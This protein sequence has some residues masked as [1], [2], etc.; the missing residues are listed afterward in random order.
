MVLRSGGLRVII[1]RDD[2]EPAHVHVRGDG[3]CKINLVG[4]TGLPELVW[5]RGMTE[6]EKRRA[7]ATVRE[8][9]F[10]LLEQWR[11]IHG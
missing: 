11:R 8:A 10:E 9:Q 2:H 6:A 1:F 3:D 4:A 5:A 7:I